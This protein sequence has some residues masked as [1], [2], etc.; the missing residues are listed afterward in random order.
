[1]SNKFNL[2][3]PEVPGVNS[4][5]DPHSLI[6]VV[7]DPNH[8]LGKTYQIDAH[9]EVV[10]TANVNLSFGLAET[11]RID[12]LDDMAS[13]LE[14]V[15][16]DPH[17]A[18]MNAYYPEIPVGTPFLILSS[19]QLETRLGLPATDRQRQLGCHQLDHAGETYVAVGRF[20]ENMQQ[21][22][23]QCI[24]RDIDQHTPERFAQSRE[25]WLQDL[26]QLLPGFSKVSHLLVGSASSRI[27]RG[28]NP[29]GAD[30]GHLW[31]K[32]TDPTDM[33]RFRPALLARAMEL[34]L[35]WKKPRY[36]RQQ[37]DQVVGHGLATILDLSVFHVGR[38]VFEGQ[39][40]I[41]GEGLSVA[42][43]CLTR[44]AGRREVFD[45]TCIASPDGERFR[46]LGRQSG[47]D[48]ELRDDG[49]GLKSIHS[50]DLTLDTLLETQDR[51]QMTVRA[52]VRAGVSDKVRCQAP[53][54]DST[55]YAA[56]FARGKEGKPF[57]HDVGTGIT[58]W[59]CAEDTPELKLLHALAQLDQVVE[60]TVDDV[61]AALE[62]EAIAALSL[63]RSQRPGDF[64]RYLDALKRANFRVSKQRIESATRVSRHT[65]TQ[66]HH[67]Y[68]NDLIT[69]LTLGGQRPVAIGDVL[70]VVNPDSQLWEPI[71]VK[72]LAREVAQAFDGQVGCRKK[73]DY[74][75]IARHA[76]DL[77]EDAEFFATAPIGL[78]CPGGFYRIQGEETIVTPLL[79]EH[80]QR[81]KLGITPEERP[82][83]QFLA[84]LATT[85]RADDPEESGQQIQRVQEVMGGIMLG[86]LYRYQKAILFYD[87]IGR[88]GKGTLMEII[89]QLVPP[90]FFTAISPYDWDREY[91]VA[92]MQG[93]RLNVAGELEQERA[94]PAAVFKMITGGD[95]L[96]GR[97][98]TG[99]PQKVHNEAAH[100]F[101][102]NHFITTKD[103]S[104][105]FFARWEIIEFPN[106]LRRTQVMPDP[107]LAQRIIDAEMP[108]IAHWA[109]R[110]AIRLLQQQ[111]LSPSR[112]HD[113][114]MEEWRQRTNSLLVFIY[115][116]CV[117]DPRAS[118]RRAAFYAT[119]LAWCKA[120]RR[121]P[122]SKGQVLKMVK[123]NLTLGISHRE[124]M[125]HETFYGIGLQEFHAIDLN[126]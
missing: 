21:S 103:Q 11:R 18:L 44:H 17:A 90:T 48:L 7:R 72:A 119:Y 16:Q 39:P 108:G 110:G 57:V 123:N 13:L 5:S 33:E 68:A 37:P 71:T 35:T 87:P 76:L 59:L 122:E 54:R 77:V 107:N 64:E 1:M 121:S 115:D 80:R 94:I 95:T 42:P 26:D 28:G 70:Y 52:L 85:F 43:P 65:I 15:G 47:M 67:A 69:T 56:F 3:S 34:G 106:S 8:R 117:L 61:G 83:P 120:M 104:E 125:G 78:A 66:T 46:E 86:F 51:G 97:H 4:Q 2:P 74:D 124:T 92:Q 29:L 12:T 45:T 100:V 23:W 82:T 114:L 111:G 118:V 32:V 73:Y 27:M 24:D 60:A 62:P 9:G 96:M 93:S 113:R 14:E 102:S 63:L 79:A 31:F 41:T 88:A 84:F 116:E 126:D 112:V 40:S 49:Q 105:A 91:Y 30:N 101:M 50:R 6:T 22:A 38:L 53:F 109:L 98:P 58:H 10:K 25:G 81:I 75:A 20:K 19:A 99:R 55:S 36:S 89:K